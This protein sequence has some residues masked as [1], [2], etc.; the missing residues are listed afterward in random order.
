LPA[1]NLNLNN[2][3]KIGG[4]FMEFEIWM[5]GN[6]QSEEAHLSHVHSYSIDTVRKRNVKKSW[7]THKFP[8]PITGHH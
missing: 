7:K 4:I 2:I 3:D 8:H 1:F 5:S 6:T